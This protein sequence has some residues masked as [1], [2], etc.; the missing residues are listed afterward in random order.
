MIIAMSTMAPTTTVHPAMIATM[1]WAVCVE[2]D[3]VGLDQDEVYASWTPSLRIFY[4]TQIM[5]Q[6]LDRPL[7]GP[8]VL[9]VVPGMAFQYSTPPATAPPKA[10]RRNFDCSDG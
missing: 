9:L 8:R 3:M 10:C 7:A 4:S 1:V 2:S 5:N 6:N